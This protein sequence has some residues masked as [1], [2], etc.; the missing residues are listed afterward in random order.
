[1]RGNQGQTRGSGAPCVLDV[2]IGHVGLRHARHR[3]R[4]LE[5]AHGRLEGAPAPRALPLKAQSPAPLIS[6]PT[7]SQESAPPGGA[8]AANNIRGATWPL[9]PRRKG[10]SLLLARLMWRLSKLST[11]SA[12]PQVSAPQQALSV[13][14]SVNPT[15][16]TPSA[17]GSER[18]TVFFSYRKSIAKQ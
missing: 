12:P 18:W 13:C 3:L 4:L 7:C 10:R 8:P 17:N 11:G 6:S 9:D 5:Q 1:M 2:A 14:E 16:G 15:Q